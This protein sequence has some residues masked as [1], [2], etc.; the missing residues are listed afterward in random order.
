LGYSGYLD[1][2]VF[3][4]PWIIYWSLSGLGYSYSIA[5]SFII[6][7]VCALIQRRT[8]HFS[9]VFTV[10]YFGATSI[11]TYALGMDLFISYSGFI[12]YLA[13]AVMTI[14]SIAIGS[15]YTF[16]VSKVDWPESYW[17]E[18]VFVYVNNV[19]TF[20]W[21]LIFACSSALYLVF[22]HPYNTISSN[23]L[24]SLGIAVSIVLPIKLPEHIVRKRYVDPYKS[25]EWRVEPNRKDEYD[26]IVVGAGVGGLACGALLARKG[27]RVLVLEHHH[28]IGG[29]CSS[30]KRREFVFNT[31]V[32]DISGLWNRGPTKILLDRLG[33]DKDELFVKIQ[34]EIH[35]QK[36]VDRC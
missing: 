23:I 10:M 11:A 29:Y 36:Y 21:T 28:Q 4:I 32:A 3:F 19:L 13:L 2:M 8:I 17:K 25:F 31:G 30:F 35:L 14:V 27:Y 34:C 7:I 22:K 16:K 26:V 24:I 20:I 9:D 6:S 33:L 5:V 18:K 12:G 1:I 15:P